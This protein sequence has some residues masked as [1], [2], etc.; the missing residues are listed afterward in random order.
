METQSDDKTVFVEGLFSSLRTILIRNSR[1]CPTILES[2]DRTELDE[3]IEFV[4]RATLT[5]FWTF[6]DSAEDPQL[7]MAKPIVVML[8]RKQFQG[9]NHG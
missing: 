6:F 4:L 3:H 8:L 9:A 7:K 1:A 2:I 5:D